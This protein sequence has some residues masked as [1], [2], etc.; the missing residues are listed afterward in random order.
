ME[1]SEWTGAGDPQDGLT[2]VQIRTTGHTC[3]HMFLESGLVK[4]HQ[5]SQVFMPSPVAQC[6][7]D[8]QRPVFPEQSPCSRHSSWFPFSHDRE[9]K[10][11]VMPLGTLCL[12]EKN[13]QSCKRGLRVKYLGH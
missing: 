8:H 7:T 9:R 10:D 12:T 2:A 6:D 5:N 3:A 13:N 1:R 11:L 4:R